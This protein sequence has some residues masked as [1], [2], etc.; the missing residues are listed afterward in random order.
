[1]KGI[2]MGARPDIDTPIHVDM[3]AK[4]TPVTTAGIT[5]TETGSGPVRQTVIELDGTTVTMTDGTTNGNIGGVKLFDFPQGAIQVL[6]VATDFKTGTTASGNAYGLARTGTG[7]S[8]TGA[9]KH[10]VGTVLV[11]TNDTLTSTKAD[12]LAS[13]SLTLASGAGV[14]GGTGVAPPAAFDGNSA[15]KSA[16]LNFGVADAD[17]T[18]NDV[19]RVRGRVVV[20]WSHLGL[21]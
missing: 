13:T 15:A 19:V 11:A 21:A 3:D 16:Y 8:A 7:I 4:V 2:N 14:V 10:S 5:V 6:G 12:L 18:G 9:L 17:S 20:L 1:L